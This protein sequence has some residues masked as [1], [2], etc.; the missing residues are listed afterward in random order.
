[1]SARAG[2]AKVFTI[3]A[4]APFLP[5][6]ARGILKRHAGGGDALKL[7][8]TL[9][10][11]PTRRAARALR[12]ALLAESG[13]AALLLPA[14]R[15][16]G[17]IDDEE[18][19]LT[20]DEDFALPP[21]I[22]PL[23]RQLLLT[24]LVLER[25]ASVAPGQAAKL[26]QALIRFLDECHTAGVEPKSVKDIVPDAYAEHWQKTIEFLQIVTET[27]PCVLAALEM[28]EPKKR[29]NVALHERIEIGRASCRERV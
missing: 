11:V 22:P 20:A 4:G 18:L 16:I 3:P 23:Q 28:E 26:A 10:L 12:E 13:Q 29:Q 25:D 24:Q 14:I 7:A 17:D 2:E 21:V 19:T 15:P 6:L 27:W 5:L 9:I 8:R 1:M